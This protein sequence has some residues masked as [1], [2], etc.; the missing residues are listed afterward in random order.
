MAH[1]E[2]QV[3]VVEQVL[4]EQAELQVV[5]VLREQAELQVERVLREQAELQVQVVEQVHQE[6]VE[7]VG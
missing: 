5:R 7:L 3:Q 4:R 2:L 6:Q 1:Q